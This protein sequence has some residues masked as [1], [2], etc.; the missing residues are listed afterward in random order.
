MKTKRPKSPEDA[1]ASLISEARQQFEICDKER[2]RITA[3]LAEMERNLLPAVVRK[4][5]RRWL[6]NEVPP[7]LEAQAIDDPIYGHILLNQILATLV[8]HP[9]LQRLAR[10]KQLSFSF[11]QFPSARHSRLSHSL[12]VAKNAEMAVNGMLNRG[13]YY[14]EGESHSFSF[15]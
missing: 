1:A 3:A 5:G 12:G 7:L 9:L 6:T 8:S 10:V 2:V 13:V 11:A 4:M 15:G 14:V